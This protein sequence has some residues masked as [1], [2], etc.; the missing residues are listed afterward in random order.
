MRH[1][2]QV[3]LGIFGTKI[4]A[5]MLLVQH[6]DTAQVAMMRVIDCPVGLAQCAPYVHYIGMVII[7]RYI[8][9]LL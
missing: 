1:A 9:H 6:M 5:P 4:A 7:V 8:V 3:S 2:V